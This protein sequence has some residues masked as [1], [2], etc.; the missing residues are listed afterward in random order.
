[1]QKLSDD[2]P[3]K[4]AFL[5]GGVYDIILGIGL[6]FFV[7]LLAKLL[8]ASKP[9]PRIFAHLVGLFL[10]TVGYF[11]LYAAQDP[12]RLAFIGAASSLIRLLYALL[13]VLTWINQDIETLYLITALTDVIT[14]LMLLGALLLT[15]GIA[16]KQLWKY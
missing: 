13:V 16:F 15:N 6:L 1:M 7:D 12:R 11:L 9:E 5:I 2:R 10:I 3:L 4:V 8:D 14:G